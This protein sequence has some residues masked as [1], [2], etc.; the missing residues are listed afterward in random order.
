MDSVRLPV[1]SSSPCLAGRQEGQASTGGLGPRKPGSSHQGVR[2]WVGSG[3]DLETPGEASAGV[4]AGLGAEWG[5]AGAGEEVIADLRAS[6][7][8]AEE[9]RKTDYAWQLTGLHEHGTLVS[10]QKAGA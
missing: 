3:K 6:A 10:G 4:P 8:Q 7:D 5:S 9:G 1:R 2:P